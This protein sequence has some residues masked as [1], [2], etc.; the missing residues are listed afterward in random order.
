MTPQTINVYIHTL[1]THTSEAGTFISYAEK[2]IC[3][4]Q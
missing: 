3:S 4:T 1:K 2:S